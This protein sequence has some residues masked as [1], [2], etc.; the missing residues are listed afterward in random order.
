MLQMLTNLKEGSGVDWSRCTLATSNPS[1]NP[2][3]AAVVR[4]QREVHRS[5]PSHSK[6]TW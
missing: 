5:S 2:N 1:P 4:L 6:Y 3:Q